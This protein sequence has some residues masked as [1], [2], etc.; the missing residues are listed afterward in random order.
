M[1]SS[2][3]AFMSSH[4]DEVQNQQKWMNK[5]IVVT[6]GARFMKIQHNYLKLMDL[7]ITSILIDIHTLVW[8]KSILK[9]YMT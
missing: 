2:P 7:Q 1:I 3:L 9:D 4:R 8:K 5:N 6:G